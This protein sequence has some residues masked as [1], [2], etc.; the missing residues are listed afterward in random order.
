MLPT[1]S[2]TTDSP[3]IQFKDAADISLN[4]ITFVGTRQRKFGQTTVW[5]Q[6]RMRGEDRDDPGVQPVTITGPAQDGSLIL[7]HTG[8]SGVI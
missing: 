6:H 8:E 1:G 2:G 5:P 4:L 7:K 3:V